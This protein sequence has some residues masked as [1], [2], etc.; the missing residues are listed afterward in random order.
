V[1]SLIDK[2]CTPLIRGQDAASVASANGLKKTRDGLLLVMEG[3]QRITLAPPTPANPHICTLTV[4]YEVDQAKPF[5]DALSG[6]SASQTP[7]LE[8]FQ[9]AFASGA[10]ATGWSWYVDTGQFHKGVVFTAQKRPDGKPQGKGYDVAYVL[11][12]LQ[13][14]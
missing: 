4:N 14:S 12:S 7:P 9:T 2:A 11:F 6:W 13:G 5:V 8:P 10:G 1:L 3:V